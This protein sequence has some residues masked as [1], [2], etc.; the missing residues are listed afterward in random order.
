[1]TETVI[2]FMRHGKPTGTST[3][4]GHGIDDPLSET[5]WEQMWA[6]VG[7]QC[8]WT[9]IVTSPLSRCRAFAEALAE[10]HALPVS[11]EDR[12]KEVG[13]GSWEGRAREEIQASNAAEYAAFYRDPV[14]CRPP[15]AEPLGTFFE[16]VSQAYEDLIRQFAGQQILVVGHAGVIRAMFAHV[17]A[18]DP[19]AAYVIKVDNA[20]ITRFQHSGSVSQL[21]FH[22]RLVL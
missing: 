14:N 9:Q 13:F 15:G 5:G 22:N 2:D 6:T 4:R 3:Y 18:A 1:M 17:L 16:R 12:F 11:V 20:G 8:P 19:R 7:D 10:R 21:V